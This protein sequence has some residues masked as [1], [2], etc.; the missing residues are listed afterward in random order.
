[1]EFEI[2][3][4][5]LQQEMRSDKKFK[6]VLSIAKEMANVIEVEAKFESVK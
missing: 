2:Q 6:N 3:I 5:K 4:K 1:M